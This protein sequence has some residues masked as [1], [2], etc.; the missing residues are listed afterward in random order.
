MTPITEV[1]V[2]SHKCVSH[3]SQLLTDFYEDCT[4]SIPRHVDLNEIDVFPSQLS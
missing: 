1:N 2:S 3:K 4:L